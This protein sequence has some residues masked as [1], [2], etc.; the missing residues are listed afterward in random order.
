MTVTRFTFRNPSEHTLLERKREMSDCGVCLGGEPDCSVEFY[1]GRT[2]KARKSH[3]CYECG[4][5]IAMGT[6]YFK[7][8]GKWD[9]E[10]G[11]FET[12]LICAEI[13]TAFTCDGVI[14]F[15]ELWNEIT[16]YL[17]PNM[18]TGCLEKLQTAEAKAFLVARWNKWKFKAKR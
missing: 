15:G 1:E 13:R 2:V 7:E 16:D 5:L 14:C 10:F 9:G 18:T 11:S 4:E 17:F 3:K 12:C 8:S 6:R